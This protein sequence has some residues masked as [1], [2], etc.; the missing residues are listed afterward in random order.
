MND[1]KDR[2]SEFEKALADRDERT[3]VLRLYVVGMTPR[4]MEAITTLKKVCEEHLKGRYEIEI[5]D[6][7]EHPEQATERQ[8]IAAPTLIKELPLPLRRF[9]GN[10]TNEARILKGLDIQQQ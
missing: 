3:Y 10:L 6:L 9:I 5:I 1:P 2:T 7:Y 8:I 4:S